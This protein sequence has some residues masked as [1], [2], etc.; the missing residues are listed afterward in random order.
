MANLNISSIFDLAGF[1]FSK[2]MARVSNAYRIL[3]KISS[4]TNTHFDTTYKN[5]S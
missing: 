3:P 1:F 5:Y 2:I 4:I